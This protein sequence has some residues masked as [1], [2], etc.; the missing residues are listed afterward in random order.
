MMSPLFNMSVSVL[1]TFGNTV[2]WA[3]HEIWLIGPWRIVS[4]IAMTALVSVDGGTMLID[5]EREDTEMSTVPSQACSK[6]KRVD[7][8]KEVH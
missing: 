7:G 1:Q 8:N 4:C 2:G 6:V 5:V 3:Y